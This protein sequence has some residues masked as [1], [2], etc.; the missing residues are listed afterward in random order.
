MADDLHSDMTNDPDIYHQQQQELVKEYPEL[1]EGHE[2]EPDV[3][4]RLNDHVD[5]RLREQAQQQSHDIYYDNPIT[6]HYDDFGYDVYGNS[7]SRYTVRDNRNN[8]V[9]IG[10]HYDISDVEQ[11]LREHHMEQGNLDYAGGGVKYEE[12]YTLPG[13]YTNYREVLTTYNPKKSFEDSI[14]ELTPEDK[15]R[16]GVN[17]GVLAK[18]KNT[19]GYYANREEAENILRQKMPEYQSS[20][21]DEPN[22]LAHMRVNDRTIN[23]K[24]TLMVEEIQSDWHQEGRKKGYA[25]QKSREE[26]ADIQQKMGYLQKDKSQLREEYKQALKTNVEIQ[27]D[28]RLEELSKKIADIEKQQMVLAERLNKLGDVPD[29]PFKKNWHELMVKQALDMAAKGDYDA[30]AFTTGKQQNARYNLSKQVDSIDLIPAEGDN[31]YVLQAWKDG[32][33][34]IRKSVKEEDLADYVGKEVADKL[35]AQEPKDL[36]RPEGIAHGNPNVF[37]GRELKGLE[38]DVGGEG[39]KGF[40]DKMLPDYINKYTKKWGMGMKKGHL[41]HEEPFSHVKLREEI[42]N[43]GITPSQFDQLSS[44]EKKT[45]MNKAR[46]LG[47]EVHIVDLSDSAKKDIKQ[48]GQP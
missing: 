3:A 34:V 19:W 36:H 46:R 42:S 9:N 15:M 11:A 2:N 25:S 48:K 10:D 30:V 4:A 29:A 1:Y 27:D 8:I 26:N 32:K 47:E 21:Y 7:D 35:L 37:Q 14:R 13:K 12:D 44:A 38:L 31:Q 40:Y 39:M 5:E 33:S 24:K 43:M 45:I 18:V 23:G 6:H 20:H 22:I 41:E 16:I 28:P 17:Q